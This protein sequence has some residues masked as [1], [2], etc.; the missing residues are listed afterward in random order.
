M[1]DLGNSHGEVLT[2]GNTNQVYSGNSSQ[3]A[4]AKKKTWK[5]ITVKKETSADKAVAGLDIG[6]KRKSSNLDR[7]EDHSVEGEKRKKIE[8]CLTTPTVEV[9]QQLRRAQ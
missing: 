6:E 2:T 9:A 7:K 5:R 4:H 1:E 3:I 8:V